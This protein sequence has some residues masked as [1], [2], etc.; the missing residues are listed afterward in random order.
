[1]HEKL[2][3]DELIPW[4]IVVLMALQLAVRAGPVLIIIPGKTRLCG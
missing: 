3:V 1:M 2:P 4:T